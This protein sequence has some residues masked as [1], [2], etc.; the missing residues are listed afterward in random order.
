MKIITMLPWADWLALITFFALWVGYAWL[1]KVRGL[2][3]QSLIATTNRYRQN[4]DDANHGARPA[5]AR[6]S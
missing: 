2:R 1:A 3:D 4:V 5:C 6:W